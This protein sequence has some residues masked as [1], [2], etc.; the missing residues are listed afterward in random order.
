MTESY[1]AGEEDVYLIRLETEIPLTLILMPFS[2][3]IPIPAGGGSFGFH[4]QINNPSNSAFTFDTW[5]EVIL[6]HGITYGPLILRENLQI[7]GRQTFIYIGINQYV[8][9]NAPPGIYTYFGKAGI[10]PDLVSAYDC[11]TFAKCTGD[12]PPAHNLGWACYGWDDG[13]GEILIHSSQFTILSSSP[14][15]FNTTANISF[16]L[17][18]ASCIKLAVYDISG[19]EA[20]KL[21]EGWYPAGIHRAAFDG[22]G[23][24]SGV[25]FARLQAGG[26]CLVKKMLLLK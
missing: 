5:S 22:N 20:S 10:Y 19:R 8:P 17:S 6:P 2:A 16:Q 23:L 24:S 14:N 12:S 9:G 26:I 7:Q 13:E 18:T 21:A 1:G 15:P 4:A 11:F 3:H 25:Y